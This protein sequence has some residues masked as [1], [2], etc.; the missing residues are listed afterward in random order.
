MANARKICGTGTGAIVE[1]GEYSFTTT[2]ATVEVPT[3]RTHIYEAQVLPLV[4]TG[5]VTEHYFCDRVITSGK[6]TVSREAKPYVLRTSVGTGGAGLITSNQFVGVP[7][8][9]AHTT[10]TITRVTT[11]L[12][13]NNATAGVMLLGKTNIT[14][15]DPDYFVTA[16]NAIAMPLSAKAVT[17]SNPAKVASDATGGFT[18]IAVTA[19]DFIYM[20]TSGTGASDPVGL[21]VEVEI[22]PTLTSGLAFSYRFVGT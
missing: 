8:G 3:L 19:G 17:T 16:A 4:T 21:V 15:D 10:G 11:Y 20:G 12:K 13:T 5:R 1:Y 14:T 18:Q 2:G 9:Y 22:T 6:V 7:I